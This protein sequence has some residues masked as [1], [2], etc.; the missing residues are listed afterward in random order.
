MKGG[1]NN[2]TVKTGTNWVCLRQTRKLPVIHFRSVGSEYPHNTPK[3]SLP[4]QFNSVHT[5]H[6]SFF[7]QRYLYN[8]LNLAYGRH[9]IKTLAERMK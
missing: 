2:Y 8:I 4:V 5:V 9:F 3:A 7:H 6:T 1:T